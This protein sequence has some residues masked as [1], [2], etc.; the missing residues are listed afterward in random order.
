MLGIIM[1][2]TGSVLMAGALVTGYHAAIS[3]CSRDAAGG[4]QESFIRLM[5]DL[6][7]SDSGILYWLAWVIGIFLIW[8]G[9]RMKKR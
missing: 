1:L 7:I 2:A 4:C 3:A 8:G 9:M 6:M 5:S